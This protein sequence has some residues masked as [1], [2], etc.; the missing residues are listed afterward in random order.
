MYNCENKIHYEEMNRVILRIMKMSDLEKGINKIKEARIKIE[1]YN[2]TDENELRNYLGEPVHINQSPARIAYWYSFAGWGGLII[3]QNSDSD[4]FR[5]LENEKISL[6]KSHLSRNPSFQE[7][8]NVDNWTRYYIGS[9]FRDIENNKFDTSIFLND[10]KKSGFYFNEIFIKRFICL[11][12][13]KPFILL[14]G[15]SGS[16][17]TKIAQIFSSWLTP[18]FIEGDNRFEKGDTIISDRKVYKVI[19]SDNIAVTFLQEETGKKVTLPYGLIK[20]WVEIIKTEHYEN[21]VSCRTIREKVAERTH[22]STQLNSF[23]SHLKASAFHYL[24]LEQSEYSE[25]S[26]ILLPVGSDWTNREPLLGYPNA[27]IP[28]EYVKPDNGVL[29]LLINANNNPDIPFFLILDEMNLSHVERYFADFLSVMESQLNIPLHSCKD[30]MKAQDDTFIPYEISLPENLFIIGTVNID[31]TTYMFSPKVLDRAGVI[32]FRVNDEEMMAFLKNPAKIDMKNTIGKGASMG[33]D[34][35]K[36]AKQSISDFPEK[37]QIN[38]E[39]LKF[40]RELREIGAEFGYR[41]AS[42][43]FQFAGKVR[44]LEQSS[45]TQA[46]QVD[47]IIDMAVVQKLLPKLH[48]SRNKLDSILRTLVGLCLVDKNEADIY[49]KGSVNYDQSKVR[50][51]LSI[52]K[53]IRMHKRLIHDGF[54]S[55]AEA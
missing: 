16:G 7:F 33:E 54:T 36:N 22:Y 41:T 51:P 40:F 53:L 15:L 19:D 3:K 44:L 8:I 55:F 17:K 46:W 43:I 23:E 39:L 20:E 42:D 13:S 49:L 2:N 25:R 32:E 4:G 34:F 24:T 48:G 50:F 47:Q 30:G 9:Y 11:L 35:L 14:T 26:V 37:E 52:E 27:L 31:E 18:K 10:T 12:M 29:D 28:G 21:D 6:I 5:H 45:E 38:D 1:N